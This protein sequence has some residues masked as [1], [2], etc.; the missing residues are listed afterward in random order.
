MQNSINKFFDKIGKLD[1]IPTASAYCQ[2]RDKIKPEIFKEMSNKAVEDFY[3]LYETKTWNSRRL[4]SV[5]G[6]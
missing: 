2:A 5:D 4:I 3:N 6:Y 1:N